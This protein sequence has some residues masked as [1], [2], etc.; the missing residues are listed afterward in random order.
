MSRLFSEASKG[1][2]SRADETALESYQRYCRVNGWDAA[3]NLTYLR[4]T[5]KIQHPPIAWGGTK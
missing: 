2:V 1:G 3:D 4:V 5:A